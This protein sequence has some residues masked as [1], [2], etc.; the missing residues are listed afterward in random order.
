M[1]NFIVSA[2]KYRPTTFDTVVGQGSVS[3][4]LKNAIQNNHLAQAFLFCGPRGVGKT[5][6]ARILAKT[7]NCMDRTA[8]IE[9]CDQCESC[10]SFNEGHSLNIYELDAAS[11]N[12]VDD[13]RN[14]IEQVRFAPQIG[15][16]KVYIIDE[17]H[18]LSTQAFNA[19]LKTLEEPPAHAI[20]ILA[21]TEKHKIIPTILSRCQVFDFNRIGIDAMT[22]HLE[23]IA[24]KEGIKAEHDGLHIVAQKADGSLRDALSMFDQIVTFTGDE[25]TYKAVIEN[26]NILDYDY[27]FKVTSHLLT[28][29]TS[30][31]LLVFDEILAHGFDGHNFLNGLAEHF[32]NLLVCQ[33]PQTLKLLEVGQ[34][35]REKYSTQ[36]QQADPKFLLKALGLCSKADVSYKGSKN[37]RLL[38]EL[39]LLQLCQL[40]Y[41]AEQDLEKKKP[42]EQ[43]VGL[44]I[45]TQ[46][47]QVAQ[48]QPSDPATTKTASPSSQEPTDPPSKP[49]S[50]PAAYPVPEQEAQ[51]SP[52]KVEE[53]A[54][55]AYQTPP[56]PPPSAPPTSR[57]TPKGIRSKTISINNFTKT[58]ESSETST[59]EGVTQEGKKDELPETAFTDE[60][61]NDAWKSL[62]DEF[63]NNG[64][65]SLYSTLTKNP[66][67]IK[68]DFVI[69]LLI[70]NK[71]QEESI[72]SEKTAMLDHLRQTLN[73]YKISLNTVIAKGEESRK[74]YTPTEKFKAITDKNPDLQKFKDQLDLE[75]GN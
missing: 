30:Q 64:K 33:D 7:I 40:Q 66:P 27:Y 19:F 54:A 31:S 57:P 60:A 35:I 15:S 3:S 23:S 69:E 68:D 63:Q 1:D 41:A 72:N 14:L 45:N 71:A 37:Q 22:A 20:F 59:T 28:G 70:D 43:S 55:A 47:K 32:R 50:E 49:K 6:C 24:E 44:P 38:V 74:A 58:S 16:K 53:P 17:V 9:P 25:V 52:E 13:I 62:A 75:V 18:M 46:K 8:A 10:L 73:N 29:D 42:V 2:R 5:T 51:A 26:L 65:Y 48:N 34:N 39:L 12:S 11:N 4:T 21:T 56:Q 67:V 61:F 36:A